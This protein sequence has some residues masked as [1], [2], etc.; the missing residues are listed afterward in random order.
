MSERNV[1]KLWCTGGAG[2]NLA[3][4][5]LVA[6]ESI[7]TPEVLAP[8]EAILIDTSESNFG[9]HKNVFNKHSTPL[10]TIPNVDGSGQKRDLNVDKVKPHIANIVNKN[11]PSKTDLN[12]IIHSCS[13]GSGS[14][15]GPMICR[16]LLKED[17]NVLVV[18]VGDNST[19]QFAY[20]T[21]A[22]IRSY[23][24]ISKQTNKPV[25]A[26]YFQNNDIATNTPKNINDVIKSIITDYRVL[27][28][29]NIHG[30]DTADLKNF[31]HYEKVTDTQ[32]SLTLISG[33]VINN[34]APANRLI[35]M[36]DSVLPAGYNIISAVT[37]KSSEDCIT[38]RFQCDFLVE[39]LMEYPKDKDKKDKLSSLYFILTD[40]FFYN[41]VVNLQQVVTD[42]DRRNSS[43]VVTRIDVDDA[44]SDGIV[45]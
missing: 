36:S 17:H 3:S 1:V 31:F 27:F 19:R 5:I 6:Q 21:Q 41:V 23:E 25:I 37:V 34:D 15:I 45:F 40:N 4:E 39:G 33:V 9:R 30:V 20:N 16:E 11:A 22:T 8:L 12:V 28:S 10:I 7:P 44:N 32:P 13:G 14:L 26:H 24:A 38:Q 18:M 2:I 35:E 43:R 42:Y 29:G